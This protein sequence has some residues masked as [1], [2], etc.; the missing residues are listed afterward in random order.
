[1]SET[2]DDSG[3]NPGDLSETAPRILPLKSGQPTSPHAHHFTTFCRAQRSVN[4]LAEKSA[5][6]GPRSALATLGPPREM[7]GWVMAVIV[8]GCLMT[9][10]ILAATL[11]PVL[12]AGSARAQR[13][14]C[15]DDLTEIGLAFKTWQLENGDEFHFNL[16]TN[17]GEKLGRGVSGKSGFDD[18]HGQPFVVMSNDISTSKILICPPDTLKQVL[19]DF[20]SLQGSNVTHRVHSGTNAADASPQSILIV[21]PVHHNVLL[22]DGSVHV[23]TEARMRQLLYPPASDSN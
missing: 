12:R 5:I 3:T 10:L 15:A 1:M 11:V 20:G 6:T 7:P 14:K 21:C 18:N 8:C 17:K 23:L 22:S 13:I 9:P 19:S 16:G 4:Q 2:Q